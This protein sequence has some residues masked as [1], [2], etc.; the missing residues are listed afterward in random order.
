MYDGATEKLHLRK[1]TL[2]CYSHINHEKI[3]F[4]IAS[5][6]FVFCSRLSDISFYILFPA[7]SADLL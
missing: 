1:K 2:S 3:I 7:N 6:L 4:L 5:L